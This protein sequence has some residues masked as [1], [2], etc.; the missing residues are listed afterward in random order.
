MQLSPNVEIWLRVLTIAVPA[1]SAIVVAAFSYWLSR[2]METHKTQLQATLQTKLYE[3]QTRYSWLHQQRAEAI[4]RLYELVA[5]V[6]TDL[7]RWSAPGDRGLTKP[8]EEFFY[9]AVDHLTEMSD[10]FD[11][12]RIFFDEKEIAELALKMIQNSKL[13]Y[14]RHPDIESAKELIP[15]WADSMKEDADKMIRQY[16]TP[17]MVQLRIELRKLLEAEAPNYQPDRMGSP[18]GGPDKKHLSEPILETDR[19][20]IGPKTKG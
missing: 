15:E 8:A 18:D 17:V 14:S 20:T 16:I 7:L 1:I 4:V 19:P 10:F 2:R 3:F 11:Q 6:H 13:L 12:K 5:R 9:D